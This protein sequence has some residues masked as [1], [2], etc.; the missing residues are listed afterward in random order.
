M[1]KAMICTMISVTIFGWNLILIYGQIPLLQLPTTDSDPLELALSDSCNDSS[2]PS[3]HTDD[4]SSD[5][6]WLNQTSEE[7][8]CVRELQQATVLSKCLSYHKPNIQIPEQKAK[9]AGCEGKAG[10]VLTSQE[11]FQTLE[12]E[13]KKKAEAQKKQGKAEDGGKEEEHDY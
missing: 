9:K 8:D 11:N 6:V 12:K 10:C 2:V 13:M 5:E 1:T 7:G 4:S 3:Q